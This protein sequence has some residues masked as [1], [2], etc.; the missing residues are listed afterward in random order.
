MFVSVA[1]QI[2]TISMYLAFAMTLPEN[3]LEEAAVP[4]WA[5]VM[6]FAFSASVGI[7]FGMF[8]AVKASRLDPIEALRHE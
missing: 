2:L 7:V 5:V 1:K 8:P 6:S 3:G 4:M